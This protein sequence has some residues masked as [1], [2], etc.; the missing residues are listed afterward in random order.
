ME[1]Q[2]IDYKREYQ[3][4][5]EKFNKAWLEEFFTVEPLDKWV[6]EHPDEAILKEGGKIYFAASGPA[7]IGT[8]ALRF[9]EDGV[10]EM[11]KMA[12]DKSYH[13]GGA[14]QFLCRAAVEKAHEMGMRKL[15]LYSNRVLENAIHIYRKMGFTEIPVVAGTYKRSD[16][17]MEINFIQQETI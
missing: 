4:Y 11:T 2:L 7:I 6:L 5:F 16:I 12:V 9:I 3:P 15:I 10:Y 17:M 13:G 8:V 1:L 14:G